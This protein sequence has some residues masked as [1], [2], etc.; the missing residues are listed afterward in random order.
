M[1]SLAQLAADENGT[2]AMEYALVASLISVALIASLTLLG[3]A[4][5]QEVASILD[6]I[7][8]AGT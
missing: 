5:R 3:I 1:Q 7:A 6:A 4:L 2:A 8:R